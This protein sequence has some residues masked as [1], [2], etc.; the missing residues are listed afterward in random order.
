MPIGPLAVAGLALLLTLGQL[1]RLHA[2]LQAGG[3]GAYTLAD[4]GPLNPAGLQETIRE[5]LDVWDL[6]GGIA[7]AAAVAHLLVD[8]AFIV[9]YFL[10]LQEVMGRALR[11]LP[12]VAS[13][14]V[15]ARS[16]AVRW[17]LVLG[18]LVIADVVENGTRAVILATSST[19]WVLVHIGWAATLVKWIALALL[20]G[21]L[22]A[23]A[24]RALAEGSVRARR[25]GPGAALWR[26]RVPLVL[27]TAW[28]AFLLL[29]PTGQLPDLL[30][31]TLDGWAG[32]GRF[33][34]T[35]VAA[36]VLGLSA[37]TMGRRVFFT[38]AALGRSVSSWLL[39]GIAA[40]F[41][42]VAALSPLDNLA[43]IAIVLGVIAALGALTKRVQPRSGDVERKKTAMPA[44]EDEAPLL[45]HVAFA[46]A[47]VPLVALLLAAGAAM[48]A[49]A[50]VLLGGPHVDSGRGAAAAA[51]A[52]L[53]PIAALA[54]AGFG[55]GLVRR[56]DGNAGAPPRTLEL[57]HVA[58]TAAALLVAVLA[59]WKPLD[60]PPALG[61]LLVA[62][63][64]FVLATVALG[65]GQR[66]G[67]AHEPPSGLRVLG[68]VRVPVATLVLIAF[69]LAAAIGDRGYHDVH[70]NGAGPPAAGTRIAAAWT[71]WKERNCADDAERTDAVP[72]VLVASYGG[73]I[74][75]AYWT[76]SVL[77][78]LLDA[79]ADIGDG[80]DGVRR[81]DRV[82]AMSAISGGAVGTMGYLGQATEPAGSSW[83]GEQLG[84]PDFLSVAVS[85]ALLVDV[86]RSILGIDPPDRAQRLEEAWEDGITGM[87]ND[88]FAGAPPQ[89]TLLGGTQVESGCRF[90]V[91][92]VRLTAQPPV[93]PPTDCNALLLRSAADPVDDDGVIRHVPDAALTSEVL[94]HLCDGGSLNRSTA[95]LLSARFP[96]VSPSG[97][98]RRCG[99]DRHTAIVDG[100]YAEG[101]GAQALLDLW[102]R[103]EPLVRAHNAAGAGPM[104]VPVFV[105]IDN[106]YAKAAR[107]GAL[108]R[109]EEV[110]VPPVA[111]SRPDALDSL[112]TEQLAN[113]TFAA[114]VPG[115]PGTTCTFG[116]G[117]TQRFIRIAPPDSPGVPAP[118]AW[119]LSR[120]ATEELDSQRASALRTPPVDALELVLD[121]G[122]ELTPRCGA[123]AAP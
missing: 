18:A 58:I 89:V 34:A 65:E 48:V 108:G 86:P 94:D 98:M 20:L 102:A 76:G 47:V 25:R 69:V 79:G 11:A 101:T 5:L 110:L 37:W 28:S 113:A 116:L 21:M 53:A 120:M 68:F 15:L 90:N 75:A 22:V 27:F 29:D 45:R 30:R 26:F 14:G 119:T 49:P 40:A 121:D 17:P 118:L 4:F 103:L 122:A 84:R 41:G 77:T 70:L 39:A 13:T 100:G 57:R 12:D 74:R 107:A 10:L 95:A 60:V 42:L 9:V 31:R 105:Q 111:A 50:V 59:I 66:Y 55:P 19:A 72:L 104:V 99:V 52:L 80:C 67:E 62:A 88:Y 109:T 23:V 64:A 97:R 81:R 38:E 2:Q 32:L 73:G 44:D 106:H 123:S 114:D 51:F 43:A 92:A 35:A 54:V 3:R 7:T 82:F 6:A 83:Y 112:G 63:A 78:D 1:D 96:Y 36:A 115:R 16:V 93:Q 61:S 91:A 117:P 56:W 8:T 24:V 71:T 46:L 33:A 85:W 87:G